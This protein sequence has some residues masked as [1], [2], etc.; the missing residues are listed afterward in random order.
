MFHDKTSSPAVVTRRPPRISGRGGVATRRALDVI[1]ASGGLLCLAPLM[2]CI[3]IGI[4]VETGFPIFF[5]QTRIGL[6]GKYF[7]LF[8]FRKFGPAEGGSGPALTL[9]DDPRMTR[10]G[11][12][13][14]KTKLDELPQFWNVLKGDMSIVGPRPES[15]RFADCFIEPF[16]RLLEHKPGVF[17]PAQVHFRNE[18]MHYVSGEDPE[19]IYR[20]VLFPAKAALDL[21]YY[22]SR[23]LLQDIAWIGR[24]IRVVAEPTRAAIARDTCLQG[25]F[26]DRKHLPRP[27]TP[28]LA[29][30]L[31]PHSI[32][33]GRKNE[34]S[35]T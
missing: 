20:Q 11:K 15:L 33:E 4:V 5:S 34:L 19:Q 25:R 8:K 21:R 6:G 27:M 3:I 14:E 31:S 1:V 28:H 17:G 7:V 24:G 13:L 12:I 32:M 16:T 9:A 35:G 26:T 2:I 23:T 10:V 22:V 30:E 29:T 18:S